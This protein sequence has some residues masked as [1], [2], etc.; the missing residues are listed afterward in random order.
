MSWRVPVS[1]QEPLNV[2]VGSKPGTFGRALERFTTPAT[3]QVV[4][5][6]GPSPGELWED[7]LVQVE[8]STT[9]TKGT[10]EVWLYIEKD[11]RAQ[12]RQL[13]MVEDNYII[14]NHLAAYLS[15]WSSISQG[16]YVMSSGPFYQNYITWP[17]RIKILLDGDDG[18]GDTLNMSVLAQVSRIG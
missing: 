9:A 16:N 17:T 4:A 13:V 14:H 1:T 15:P 11:P 10:R 12:L 8:L 5:D 7:L 2:I 3:Y 18:G 6:L